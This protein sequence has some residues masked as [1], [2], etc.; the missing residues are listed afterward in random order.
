MSLLVRGTKQGV[1]IKFDPPKRE[2]PKT[3]VLHLPRSRP[4]AAAWR[5]LR[6]SVPISGNAGIFPRFS[7][8]T[9]KPF[10]RPPAP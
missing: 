1:E 9:A 6:S 4:L 3:I 2:P 5:A 8:P 7:V 10:C